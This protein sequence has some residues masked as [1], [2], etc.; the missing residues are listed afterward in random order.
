MGPQPHL[1]IVATVQQAITSLL[2]TYE[3]E[4]LRM[5]YSLFVAF[6]T[7]LGPV[8]LGSGYD[9]AGHSAFYLFLGRT[10]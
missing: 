5:G 1:A 8:Y 3:P 4:F 6:A 7:F 9:T 10:F 2:T